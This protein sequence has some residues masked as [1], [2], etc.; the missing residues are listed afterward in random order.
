[1]DEN[2][3]L[4]ADSRNIL[5]KVKQLFLSATEC[6]YRVSDIRQMKIYIAEPLLLKPRPFDVKSATAN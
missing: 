6:I 2:D 4:L 1:M 5:R 3:D